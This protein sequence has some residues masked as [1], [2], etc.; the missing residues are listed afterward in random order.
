MIP[1]WIPIIE[2]EHDANTDADC[3]TR[4]SYINLDDCWV[5]LERTALGEL[6]W[7]TE[8]F[9]SGLPS[10]I[11][12][13]HSKS[14]LFGLYTAA[15]NLTCS[16]G[17]RVNPTGAGGAPGSGGSTA[18]GMPTPEHYATDA[19]TFALWGVDYVKLDWCRMP[20]SAL[21][22]MQ[23]MT[24]AFSSA[25]NATGRSM[26]LNFHCL[27]PWA[28]WCAVEGNSWRIGPDHHDSWESLRQVALILG[29]VGS[30]GGP[31]RW[32]DPDFLMT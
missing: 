3:R 1:T 29:E 31:Y 19:S 28:S 16:N 5:S 18:A 2:R 10:L 23:A 21:L 12:W 25:M 26:W 4:Y 17:G 8:R 13:L 9:P 15:G 22:H 24:T 14:F 30:H 6:T 27:G 20:D 32:N 7:D 11:E